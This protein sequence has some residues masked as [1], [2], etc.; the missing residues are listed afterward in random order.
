MLYTNH[1]QTGR[2]ERTSF[3]V[4]IAV[5]FMAP[6]RQF[7]YAAFKKAFDTLVTILI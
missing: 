2:N 4:L 7:L 6:F 5:G 3:V 1:E